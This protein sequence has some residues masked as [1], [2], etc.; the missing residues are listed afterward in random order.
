LPVVFNAAEKGAGR[1]EQGNPFASR[2]RR[3]L[4]KKHDYLT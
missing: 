3:T 2:Q 4:F 1:K